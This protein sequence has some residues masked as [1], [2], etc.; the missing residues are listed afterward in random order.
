MLRVR[1]VETE[2]LK[3]AL[4]GYNHKSRFWPRFRTSDSYHLTKNE[5]INVSTSFICLL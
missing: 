1:S 2:K 4:Q 5:R 3:D